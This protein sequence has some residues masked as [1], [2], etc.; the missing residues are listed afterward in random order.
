[1]LATVLN[2]LQL[3]VAIPYLY[4]VI[5]KSPPEL[6][7][8]RNTLLNHS[9]WFFLW[10]MWLE[11]GCGGS[12]GFVDGTVCLSLHGFMSIIARDDINTPIII[13]LI[14]SLNFILSLI[15]CFTFRYIQLA[16]PMLISKISSS[17][18][19]FL[20]V[21]AHILFSFLGFLTAQIII[22]ITTERHALGVVYCCV[23]PTVQFHI[24]L[25][26]SV[27]FVFAGFICLSFVILTFL[28]I[29]FFHRH[30][31]MMTTKTYRLQL[32]LTVNLILLTV[33]P[34]VFEVIPFAIIS[35]VAYAQHPSLSSVAD[36]ALTVPLG[37]GLLS[38]L[39]TLGFVTPY[40]KYLHRVVRKVLNVLFKRS[41]SVSF[42][43][44]VSNCNAG[45]VFS[46]AN[47]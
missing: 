27:I 36:V 28:C 21:A 35:V 31:S 24:F 10:L 33:L 45:N 37:D 20:L 47:K 3:I 2:G 25:F 9:L 23:D 11:S 34:V 5:T 12:V 17:R 4:I 13:M 30:M 41:S 40:R 15:I 7:V 42:G 14:I 39:L 16:H 44:H 29:R 32:L 6:I 22:G 38:C 1:M 46:G 19:V 43:V 8:Y 18:G 26:L